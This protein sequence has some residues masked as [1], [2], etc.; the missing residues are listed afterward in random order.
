[1][2]PQQQQ[3]QQQNKATAYQQLAEIVEGIKQEKISVKDAMNKLQIKDGVNTRPYA[4]VTRSGAVALYGISKDPIVLYESQW[5]R[6][7]KTIENGY[8]RKYMEHNK[9]RISHGRKK[10]QTTDNS[11]VNEVVEASIATENA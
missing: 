4:K 7:Q 3:Q 5:N 10:S 9:D 2:A 1:M 11:A 6:L 8:L